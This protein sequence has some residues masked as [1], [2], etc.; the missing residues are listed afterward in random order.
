MNI[1]ERFPHAYQF[2]A[3]YFNPD[4]GEDYDEPEGVVAQFIKDADCQ[5]RE[6]ALSDLRQIIEE[7]DGADLNKVML[8][9]ACFYSPERYRGVPMR[10][11]LEEVITELEQSL[12]QG[13]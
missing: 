8:A 10:E 1:S 9:I 4:W 5:S 6:D 13:N 3:S 2:L 7:F 11:W 12:R